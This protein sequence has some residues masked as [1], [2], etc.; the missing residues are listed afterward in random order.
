M[1]VRKLDNIYDP[2]PLVKIWSDCDS[3]P[4]QCWFEYWNL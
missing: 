2:L 4:E 3:W 1:G